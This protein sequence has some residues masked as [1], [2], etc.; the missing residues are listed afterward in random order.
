MRNEFNVTVTT[1]IN[2]LPKLL[3]KIKLATIA[4]GLVVEVGVLRDK[5]ARKPVIKKYTDPDTWD[6]YTETEPVR[7]N[8]AELAYI[9]ENG[10]FNDQGIAY[11]FM[12]PAMKAE[13]VKV[14]RIMGEA[15]RRQFKNRRNAVYWGLVE[16]GKII[17]EAMFAHIYTRSVIELSYDYLKYERINQSDPPLVDSGQ[18]LN[19]I[20]HQ[21]RKE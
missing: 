9:L 3:D 15:T 2:N 18:L 5:T 11:P 13:Q 19:S 16:C 8:N 1:P 17:S 14:Y 12:A 4:N 6:V 7:Y 20:G 10:L 21:V